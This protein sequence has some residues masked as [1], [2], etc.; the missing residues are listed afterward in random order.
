MNNLSLK[1]QN[2]K[3]Y[4]GFGIISSLCPILFFLL[5]IFIAINANPTSDTGSFLKRITVFFSSSGLGFGIA[6]ILHRCR[7]NMFSIVG[8]I[9]NLSLFRSAVIP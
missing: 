4:S 2:G 1:P 7:N 3:T 6:G 9:V 5:M 8:I